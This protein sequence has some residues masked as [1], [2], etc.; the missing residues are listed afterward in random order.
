MFL[1]LQLHHVN[2][3]FHLILKFLFLL[4]LFTFFLSFCFVRIFWFII[5]FIFL[6]NWAFSNMSCSNRLFLPL[7][8][9]WMTVPLHCFTSRFKHFIKF[10][11]LS[12]T[13]YT[14]LLAHSFITWHY[15]FY[16]FY[17]FVIC[18]VSCLIAAWSSTSLSF[19]FFFF[20]LI[21]FQNGLQSLWNNTIL[22]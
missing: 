10:A 19:V 4:F 16:N 5:L 18:C 21:Y 13:L 9:K 3:H 6:F 8:K 1:L 20:L 11:N 2:S 22:I 17:L 15:N 7:W 14:N 12:I